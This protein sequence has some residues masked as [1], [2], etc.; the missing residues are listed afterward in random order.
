MTA[1]AWIAQRWNLY[2]LF[3]LNDDNKVE[4]ISTICLWVERRVRS[5]YP[6]LIGVRVVSFF[7][8]FHCRPESSSSFPLPCLLLYNAVRRL[9]GGG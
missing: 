6:D 2:G 5:V 1:E 9:V 7:A 8:H 4:F 3:A